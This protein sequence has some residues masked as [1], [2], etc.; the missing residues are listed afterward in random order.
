MEYALNAL[1]Y[2]QALHSQSGTNTTTGSTSTASTQDGWALISEKG[3]PLHR[4][5]SPEISATLPVYKG[6]RVIEG[7][8]AEEI[9]AVVTSY[10]ARKRW[11]ERFVEAHVLEAFAGAGGA[12][13]AFTVSKASF[14]FRDRGFY[15]ASI[16]ARGACEGSREGGSPITNNATATAPNSSPLSSSSDGRSL[17][18]FY[19]SA[20]FPQEFARTFTETMYNPNNLPIG[21]MFIDGWILET[22]DPYT[23]E[24]YAIPSTRCTRV[25]AAD[26]AGSL[27]AAVNAVT[28]TTLV[29]TLLSVE[30]YVKSIAS[31]PF[32]RLPAAGVLF[33]NN[34]DNNK[35]SVDDNEKDHDESTSSTNTWTLK[36]RDESRVLVQ[37]RWTPDDRVY[38]G[39]LLVTVP[40]ESVPVAASSSSPPVTPNVSSRLDQQ[41][42]EVV[43]VPASGLVGDGSASGGVAPPPSTSPPTSVPVS[44]SPESTTNGS[45][46][47]SSTLTVRPH[48]RSVSSA[49]VTPNTV[50]RRVTSAA[51]VAGG[52]SPSSE[53]SLRASSSAFTV[54]GEVRQA[55]DL[56]IAEVVVDSKLY[57]E[58]YQVHLRSRPHDT[59]KPIP[60]LLTTAATATAAT[61]ALPAATGDGDVAATAAE[62]EPTEVPFLPLTHTVHTLPSSPLHSSGLAVDHP[63]RHLLRLILPTAQTQISTLL[64][65]L[66]GETRAPPP[67]PQWMLD[68]CEK[69][70][71]IEVEIRPATQSLA[72]GS[73]KTK[74]GGATVTIDGVI[75]EVEGEKESLTSLGREELQDDRV[76]WMAVL[77]R[78]VSCV[79]GRHAS[80]LLFN[81]FRADEARWC[82]VLTV[83]VLR[84]S[85]SESEGD[86]LP[87]EL[88]KAS[89]VAN[90]LLEPGAESEEGSVQKRE[91][92]EESIAVGDKEGNEETSSKA[93]MIDYH[94]W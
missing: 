67:K 45:S 74:G 16:L 37:T 75:V 32:T 51:L 28:N 91:E 72:V 94:I 36:R 73:G 34:N 90:I 81:E 64:D 63:P 70:A 33:V 21:R 79:H 14:P 30:A 65:P 61:T 13:T 58:G 15:L 7:V 4:K 82:G 59:N 86:E 2:L 85:S 11:D 78:C 40:A 54:R 38:R 17:P 27:P 39:V 84:H 18:L 62:L 31:L 55:V 1:R 53:R 6:G 10:D 19:V 77:S 47:S 92:G 87:A 68:L 50:R 89:A 43:V 44:S 9:A 12:H 60:L 52:R 56:L 35:R 23:T 24:N 41:T 93:R 3:F 29:K 8:S 71:V 46:S 42:K 25:V 88:R 80:L 20:S 57:P 22:L 48:S 26:Y 5:V 66:T 76:A 49:T 69:G 83:G